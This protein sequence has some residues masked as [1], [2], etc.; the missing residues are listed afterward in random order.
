MRRAVRI[1]G[2]LIIVA[3]LA[4]AAVAYASNRGAGG[5]EATGMLKV[6]AQTVSVLDADGEVRPDSAEVEQGETVVTDADG[7]ARL[8]WFDGSVTR[9]GPNSQMTITKLRGNERQRNIAVTLDVGKTWHRVA[10]ATSEGSAYEVRTANAVAAVRGTSFVAACSASA[11]CMV[12]VATG[13]V[14]VTGATGATRSVTAG[15]QVRVEGDAVGPLETF[16]PD[17]FVQDAVAADAAE[18]V[19]VP[20]GFPTTTTQA[21]PTTIDRGTRIRVGG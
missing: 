20:A 14:E 12:G 10:A 6:V 15:Q 4:S 16:T 13:V 18:G 7:V 3:G 1:L 9:I 17:E 2:V 21:P 19:A 5:N 11:S 8:A